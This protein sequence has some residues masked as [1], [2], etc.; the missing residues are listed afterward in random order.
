MDIYS[1]SHKGLRRFVENDDA[2]RLDARQVDRIR[3]IITALLV[4]PTLD[5][6]RDD[7]PASWRVHELKGARKGTWAVKVT[8]NW[9]LTFEVS[10]D[11]I[12]T[13]N[14]EDYH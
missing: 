6:F 13:L 9:R 7:A 3:A 10:A 8:G 14:L 11:G 12:E 2:G 5:V 4:A 1:I